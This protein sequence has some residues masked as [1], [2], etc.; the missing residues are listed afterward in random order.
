MIFLEEKHKQ[1]IFFQSDVNMGEN[2]ILRGN[3]DFFFFA[4]QNKGIVVRS[5]VLFYFYISATEGK[6]MNIHD[7][8]PQISKFYARKNHYTDK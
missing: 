8:L 5:D 2:V 6:T 7:S 3:L 4:F 1:S